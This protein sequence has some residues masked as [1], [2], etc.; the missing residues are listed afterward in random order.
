VQ[1]KFFRTELIFY[2][3]AK[4]SIMNKAL[5][6]GLTVLC[7]MGCGDQKQQ[8]V[9][10]KMPQ[11]NMEDSKQYVA[12]GMKYLGQKDVVNAIKNFDQAI[13]LNPTD[14]E[15]YIVLGQVYLRL[16][17]FDRAIDTFLAATKVAPENGGAYYMLATAYMMRQ[18]KAGAIA[19]AKKS[20][21]IFLQ[22]RDHDGFKRAAV[23][24][25]RLS[26]EPPQQN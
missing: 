6:C 7:L 15:N 24:L 17:N 8:Q 4:G 13:K 26:V 20:A 3:L 21:E 11:A 23:L 1:L 5:I 9:Q 18:D 25:K 19:A 2:F 14:P 10:K 12:E 16:N 22:Q